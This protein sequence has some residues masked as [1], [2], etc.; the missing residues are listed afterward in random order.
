MVVLQ[1]L[2]ALA[3]MCVDYNGFFKL[4]GMCER[5]K[6]RRVVVVVAGAFG[7]GDDVDIQLLLFILY[8]KLWRIAIESVINKVS[9]R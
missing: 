3:A 5:T 9:I 1:S 2:V 4:D 8:I 7:R 6:S